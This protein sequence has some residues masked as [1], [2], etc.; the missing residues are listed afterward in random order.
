MYRL[1]ENIP[2][3]Q[4]DNRIRQEPT[5]KEAALSR[6]NRPEEP[7]EGAVEITT[8]LNRFGRPVTCAGHKNAT[9][10]RVAFGACGQV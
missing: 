3:S 6:G 4:R 2:T 10:L 5:A 8:A 7:V 9:P 1:P